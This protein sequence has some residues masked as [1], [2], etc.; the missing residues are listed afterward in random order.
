ML[1]ISIDMIS[2]NIY[3]V[4]AFL[5]DYAII[6][7]ILRSFNVESHLWISFIYFCWY[8]SVINEGS[9][10]SV[11]NHVDSRCDEAR[12]AWLIRLV[13]AITPC[14][15]ALKPDCSYPSIY[16]VAN[17]VPICKFKRLTNSFLKH[18]SQNFYF[19]QGK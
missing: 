13:G 4:N 5:L 18:W 19:Y 12:F 2:W 14:S 17:T 11:I 1:I 16:P 7:F 3:C 9:L 6:F 8:N 15:K 10:N